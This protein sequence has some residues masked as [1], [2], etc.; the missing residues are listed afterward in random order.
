MTRTHTYLSALALLA[1]GLGASACVVPVELAEDTDMVADGSAGSD[2]AMDDDTMG[3]GASEGGADGSTGDEPPAC[4]PGE[5]GCDCIEDA[6]GGELVCAEGECAV[7][8][9]LCGN[10]QLDE[11]EDC[12]DGNL[13]D[14][15]GCNADCRESATVDLSLDLGGEAERSN[16]HAV[17]VD[18]TDAIVLSG[19]EQ[20]DSVSTGWVRKLD[21]DGTERWLDPLPEDVAVRSLD[22][23]PDDQIAAGGALTPPAAG[24]G[25]HWVRSYEP[26][27][28]IEQTWD[29]GGGN[30]ESVAFTPDGMLL[31]A[32]YG[33]VYAINVEPGWYWDVDY[34]LGGVA[35]DPAGGFVA[36]GG[37]KGEASQVIR[38]D[39]TKG[40]STP[41]WVLEE[42]GV[43]ADGVAFDSEGNI[44]VVG[45]GNAGNQTSAS[46]LQKLA[47][48]GTELWRLEPDSGATSGER[49]YAVAVDSN[50]R[51]VVAGDADAG[52]S[53]DP[54]VAKYGPDGE[55]RWNLVFEEGIGHANDVA[56]NS[57]DEILVA[58]QVDDRAGLLRLTP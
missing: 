50:D 13:T 25:N 15:D 10:D 58:T 45:G 12:D 42:P 33:R 1:V 19:Y 51:I 8:E 6:C 48:D 20:V 39:D 24:F 37:G 17:A 47:P 3:N 54:W 31:S 46:W 41:A 40:P 52:L 9:G 27:G 7:L 23:G 16:A 28:T 2:G 36:V 5:L 56:I 34:W 35:V 22:T 49:A 21:P 29:P 11:G 55:L 18:S 44:I 30:T 38:F 43:S 57:Q 26:D 53:E 32:A 4:P 14:A